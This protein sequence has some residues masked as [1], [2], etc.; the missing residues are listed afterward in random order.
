MI[1]DWRNNWNEGNFPFLYVQLPNF[2][3]VKDQPSESEWAMLREA[4]LQALSLN[5][6]GMAVTIDIGEWSDIHPLDKKDV[7]ERLFIAAEKV[8]YGNRNNFV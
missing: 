6:T 4:Q 1:N 3:D 7:G 2:M 8:A 5:N